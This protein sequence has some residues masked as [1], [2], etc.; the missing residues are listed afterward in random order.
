VRTHGD[1]VAVGLASV[2]RGSVDIGAGVAGPPVAHGR[3]LTLALPSLLLHALTSL[4]LGARRLSPLSPVRVIPAVDQL[5]LN[6]SL[7]VHGD[8]VDVPRL[9]HVQ[10]N[11]SVLLQNADDASQALRALQLRSVQVVPR[12]HDTQLVGLEDGGEQ[13]PAALLEVVGVLS[14][15]EGDEGGVGLLLPAGEPLLLG[16]RVPAGVFGGGQVDAGESGH[17]FGDPGGLGVGVALDGRDIVVVDGHGD[18]A[19]EAVAESGVDSGKVEVDVGDD[20]ALGVFVVG[21]ASGD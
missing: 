9:Q 14:V 18:A 10:T 8:L 21:G 20:E 13:V 6:E 16:E 7:R 3:S 1:G 17:E 11:E 2:G 12:V 5:P 19:H 15:D 4:T